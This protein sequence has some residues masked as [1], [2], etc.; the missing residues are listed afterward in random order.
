MHLFP[1]TP[2]IDICIP[3]TYPYFYSFQ[4]LLTCLRTEPNFED[5]KF[6]KQ[7]TCFAISVANHIIQTSF[8]HICQINAFI[9]LAA[10]GAVKSL[11]SACQINFVTSKSKNIP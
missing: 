9:M 11:T 4:I 8:G 6:D 3:T 10:L 2:L 7:N 1:C 5:T